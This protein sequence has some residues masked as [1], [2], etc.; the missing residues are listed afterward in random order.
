MEVR[1]QCLCGDLQFEADVDPDSS[2]IC[3]C[4]D[5]Q[6]L[7]GSAFRVT[8]FV[9]DGSFKMSSGKAATYIKVA[10]SGRRRELGFCPRCGTSIYSRPPEGEHG[11]FGLRVGSLSQR[12]ALVPR[13]QVW[14][15]SAQRW[16][17]WI[18]DIPAL[19][20]N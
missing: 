14:R 16:I 6:T 7:S 8:V 12:D 4:T 15:Q 3:H 10:D 17:A 1:G 5:C 2:R 11:H 18:N 19:D 9:L 13:S 20:R